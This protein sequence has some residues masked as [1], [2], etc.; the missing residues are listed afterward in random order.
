VEP[1]ENRLL[2]TA[3]ADAWP[4]VAAAFNQGA[5]ALREASPVIAHRAFGLDLPAV[6]ESLADALGLADQLAG[7]FA[8]AIQPDAALDQV[9]KDLQSAGFTVERLARTPDRGGDFI[10]LTREVHGLANPV[11]FHLGGSTAFSYWDAA[12]TGKMAGTLT[13]RVEDAALRVTFGVDLSGFGPSFYVADSSSLEVRGLAVAGNAAGKLR[14]GQ[15]AAVDAAGT[16][17]LNADARLSLQDPDADHKLRTGD[18]FSA[19][20]VV[21]DV[22]GSVRLNNVRLTARLPLLPAISWSGSW[23]V[24]V[25]HNQL[26]GATQDLVAPNYLEV[27]RDLAGSFF[28]AAGAVPLLGPIAARLNEKLPVVQQSPLELLGLDDALGWLGQKVS[29]SFAGLGYEQVKSRLQS[30]GVSLG[31]TPAN[32]AAQLDKFMHG[33]PVSFLRFHRQYEDAWQKTWNVPIGS[34]GVPGVAGVNL[35]AVVKARLDWEFKVGLG[36]DTSGFWIDP[37]THVHIAAG[38]SA[39]L[40]GTVTLLGWDLLQA[41]GTLGA[42][43]QA[44]LALT[45]PTPGDG[46]IYL[47]EIYPNLT[48]YVKADLSL[49]LTARVEVVIDVW[50]DTWV[51]WH[52]DWALAWDY[53]Y[54]S[55][56]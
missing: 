47:A 33:Q 14:I 27:V 41:T 53:H 23:S 17:E 6:G 20:T 1:L 51:V 10:R 52:H 25:V 24:Q 39:G 40:A 28:Q 35:N 49:S 21:G 56:S 9:A 18:F 5:K 36:I 22:N 42:A 12:V 15:L 44:D 50:F 48:R 43:V 2:L 32:A 46:K 34:L 8:A 19:G 30:Y 31:I 55:P 29:P 4:D 13:G 45:D 16:A 37:R 7:A 11:R 3:R 38:V 26:Q 54:P